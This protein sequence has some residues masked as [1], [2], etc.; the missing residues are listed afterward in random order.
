MEDRLRKTAEVTHRRRLRKGLEEPLSGPYELPG[1]VQGMIDAASRFE[2][3]EY[4]F[5]RTIRIANHRAH[6]DALSPCM[7]RHE[8]PLLP[9]SPTERRIGCLHLALAKRTVQSDI[10]E[11]VEFEPADPRLTNRSYGLL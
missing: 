8:R 5:F 4:P 3:R 10:D 1:S 2:F 6:I 9:F 7:W 11:S